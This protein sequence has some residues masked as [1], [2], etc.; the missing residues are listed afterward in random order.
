[1]THWNSRWIRSL[2]FF[3][4]WEKGNCER[5]DD[6]GYIT[7]SQINSHEHWFFSVDTEVLEIASFKILLP[8]NPLKVLHLR[9]GV[10]NPNL[11]TVTLEELVSFRTLPSAP[12]SFLLP[13]AGLVIMGL[14]RIHWSTPS[15]FTEFIRTPHPHF[16]DQPSA[17]C[18]G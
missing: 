15:P 6:K 18:K 11:R 13:R 12:L 3:S 10:S 2:H 4:K 9:S 16:T 14:C 1:M 8:M 17:Y 5:E 7:P